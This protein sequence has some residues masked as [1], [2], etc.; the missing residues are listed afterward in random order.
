L[1]FAVISVM[2]W[3]FLIMNITHISG[4]CS[5][6]RQTWVSR[7]LYTT[8]E[9]DTLPFL[10]LM[11]PTWRQIL[12][13]FWKFKYDE[14]K[15]NLCGDLK[16]VPLLF[17][18]QLGYKKYCY[19]LCDW[20]S[21][22]KKYHYVNQLWHKRTSLKPV[23]KNVLNPTLVLPEKIYLPTLYIKI[24]LKKTLW[25]VWIKSAVDSNIWGISSQTWGMKKLRR[26]YL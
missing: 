2:L 15:W 25:K 1:R 20:D 12:K 22:D 3:K 24:G 18:M 14:F 4:A 7:W 23:D 6:I 11:Q 13:T 17:G 26:V 9:I 10:W 16:V 21:R 8:T 19:L 5:L